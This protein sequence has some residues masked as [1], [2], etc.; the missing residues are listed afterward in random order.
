VISFEEQVRGWVAKIASC[1]SIDDQ[2]N[3]YSRLQELIPFFNSFEILPFSE[4]A[5]D[6]FKAFRKQKVRLGTMDLKIASIAL[7]FDVLLLSANL[8]DFRK[9]PALRVEDW[10]A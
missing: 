8:V 3:Q 2:V 5:A 10:T 6:R 4:A 1:K 7:A 9:V